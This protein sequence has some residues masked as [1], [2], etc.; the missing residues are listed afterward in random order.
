VEHPGEALLDEFRRRDMTIS[1]W[2]EQLGVWIT[3]LD[4]LFR[5]ERDITPELSADL[6]ELLGTT[7]LFWMNMQEQWYEWR[8]LRRVR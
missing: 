3:D 7:P 8:K 2:A 1:Y 5:G 4:M 6:G